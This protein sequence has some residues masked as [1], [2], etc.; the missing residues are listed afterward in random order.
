MIKG[1]SH[2]GIAVKNL[3]DSREFY[4]RIFN[5]ESSD[6]EWFGRSISLLSPLETH[7]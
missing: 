1:I 5:F 3:E 4:R 7:I 6:P 2:I